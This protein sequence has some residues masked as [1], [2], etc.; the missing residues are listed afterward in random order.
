MSAFEDDPNPF[1]DDSATNEGGYIPPSA[2]AIGVSAAEASSG[3]AVVSSGTSAMQDSLAALEKELNARETEC[4]RQEALLQR[5]GFGQPNW[6]FSCLPWVRH[7][8]K[9][10]IP[11][12]Y[13]WSVRQ[14]YLLWMYLVLCL[15]LNSMTWLALWMSPN[16]P[17]SN[18]TTCDMFSFLHLLLSF[19]ELLEPGSRGT[20]R[21]MSCSRT[22]RIAPSKKR[23]RSSSSTSVSC[24]G[25]TQCT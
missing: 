19:L 14:Y 22:I 5:Q 7:S 17:C 10:D 1:A 15:L 18:S 16:T 24:T 2:S 11:A 6:P 21:C 13:W 23:G 8:I 12:R 20:S 3:S 9:E 25:S 4:E